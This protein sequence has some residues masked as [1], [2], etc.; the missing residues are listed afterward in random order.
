MLIYFPIPKFTCSQW[1]FLWLIL[2]LLKISTIQSLQDEKLVDDVFAQGIT[3]DLRYPH[4]SEGILTT[5]Q[6]GVIQ[7]KDIRIQAKKIAYTNKKL[8]NSTVCSLIAEDEVMLEFGPY[9]FVGTHLDYDFQKNCGFI[10]NARTALE[11]WFFGGKKIELCPDGNYKI[12]QGYVTTSEN[13]C[14]EWQITADEVCLTEGQYVFAKNVC[15]TFIKLPLFWLPSFRINLETILD[16][17]IRY[18]VRWGGRQGPRIG[19]TYEIFSWNNWKTFL[20]LDYRINRGL[21]GGFETY[22]HSP[23]RRAEFRS[24]NYVARDSSLLHPNEKIR[25]RFQGIY[26]NSVAQDRVSIDMTYD[27]LSDKDMA[28]DYHDKSLELETALRTK[29]HVRRQDTSWIANFFTVVRFN[30]FQTIKQELP[31][32]ETSWKPLILGSTGVITDM[33]FRASYLDFAYST[34]NRWNVP[35]YHSTR[36]AYT[37]RFYRSWRLGI[38]NISP[39]IGAKCIYYGNSPQKNQK[40]LT[41]AAF[42]MKGHTQFERFYGN[43]KHVVQPYFAYQYLTSPTTSPPEHYIFDIDD[44]WHRLNILRFGATQSLF[45]KAIPGCIQRP[46]FADLYA[47]AFFDTPTI[48]S[49]VPKVYGQLRFSSLDTLRHTF[50]TAWDFEHQQLEEYNFRNDWTLSADLAFSLEYR[51]RSA[52]RWRKVDPTN[53]ILDSFRSERSL[54][55]SA[56]SDRRDTVLFHIFYRFYPTWSLEFESRHGWDRRREPS[57]NEFEVDLNTTLRSCWHIQLSYRHKEDDDRIAIYLSVGMKRPD[58]S[59]APCFFPCLE[60]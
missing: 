32:I 5:E 16:N 23:D 60:F 2:S 24:I 37:Q 40:F 48:P 25:Y 47:Y 8:T 45:C 35:D 36:V 58:T 46:L 20:R 43:C 10:Y 55:H 13:Y 31:S 34:P 11:P 19:M 22:Y 42:G 29:L 9:V 59:G 27:K 1:L 56:L 6:G 30:S 44:G 7:G 15:F 21:G 50:M 51:H 18:N 4:F 39:E 38:F 54:K 53:F 26:H 49:I 52:Y 57:Y 28:T 41:F 33:H 17:P 14:P 3:V 12:Y